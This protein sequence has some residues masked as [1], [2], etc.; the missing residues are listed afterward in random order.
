MAEC[1]GYASGDNR[2]LAGHVFLTGKFQ[3]GHDLVIDVAV[4]WRSS[5][6]DLS[7]S[8]VH[9]FQPPPPL[10]QTPTN[11]VTECRDPRSGFDLAIRITIVPSTRDHFDSPLQR[12]HWSICRHTWSRLPG[13]YDS[14]LK[15]SGTGIAF[16]ATVP[17]RLCARHTLSEV[18]A[19]SCSDQSYLW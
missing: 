18:S 14:N 4:T 17:C 16:R 13:F 11:I 7:I 3:V 15:V 19:G 1:A 6:L 2:Q 9:A 5:K 10:Q 8:L 12:A